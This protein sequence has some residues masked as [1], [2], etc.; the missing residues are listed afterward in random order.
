MKIW[1]SK[2]D[3]V[4]TV[5]KFKLLNVET[6]SKDLGIYSRYSINVKMYF[7]YVNTML[8]A[9]IISRLVLS[10]LRCTRLSHIRIATDQQY[11]GA[12]KNK[13]I[14]LFFNLKIENRF[15]LEK[16]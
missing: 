12:L 11:D 16:H 2:Y 8:D 13:I 4:H 14:C 7:D 6:L 1:N 5:F 10:L 9:K 15:Q 3:L